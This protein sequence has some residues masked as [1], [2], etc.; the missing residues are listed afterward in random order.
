MQTDFQVILIS[1]SP[2]K[3]KT[4][5]RRLPIIEKKENSNGCLS[6]FL[7]EQYLIMHANI[8]CITFLIFFFQKLV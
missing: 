3:I 7:A 2:D 5:T 6:F 8:L 4:W 1:L